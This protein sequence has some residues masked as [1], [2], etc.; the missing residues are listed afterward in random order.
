LDG[1]LSDELLKVHKSYFEIIQNLS[2]KKLVKSFSHITGGGIE[3]NTKRLLKE[4]LKLRIDWETWERPQIFELIQSVGNV[5]ESDM[6][7]TFN[8]GIGLVFIIPQIQHN[9]LIDLV[10]LHEYSYYEIG[11]VI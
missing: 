9:K 3:G 1:S 6:Q 5:P 7:S 8:L 4:D 2:S 11:E 10:K